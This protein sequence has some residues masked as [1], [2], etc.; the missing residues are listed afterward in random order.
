ME[1]TNYQLMLDKV[2]TEH[3]KNGERPKLLL[4]CCCAPCSSYVL[5]YLSQYMDIT[6]YYYNPNISPEEEYIK[7]AEELIS[8]IEK[9]P[10][11]STP[12]TVI[13][14]YDPE[15]PRL[16]DSIFDFV[17][18]FAFTLV[19]VMLLTTFVVRHAIV[20]GPSMMNTLDDGDYL[21]ISDLFYTPERGDIIVFE[22]YSTSLKKAVIKRVIGLP[23]ET[24]EV[25]LNENKEI[26]VYI[27]GELLLED[28]TY[29]AKDT[30]VDPNTLNRPVTVGENEIFVMGDNRYHSADSR[31]ESVGTINIDTILGKVIIRFYPFDRFGVVE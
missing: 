10:L 4:H 29:N 1:K 13:A 21:I 16:I 25:R 7:R 2:I 12:E 17:E 3:I 22:D 11:S 18:L 23:G 19:A 27:N 30:N 28:Y 24:V 31:Y 8:L 9:M 26:V 14:K 6:C 5:E 15:N 20:S